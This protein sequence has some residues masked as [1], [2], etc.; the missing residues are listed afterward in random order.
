MART[1]SPLQNEVFSAIKN[2]NSNISVLATAGSGKTTT[3][4]EGL[5]YV[6]RLHKTMFLSFSKSI[7][8]ELKSKIPIHVQ[9]ATLHS[10]GFGMMRRYFAGRG[11]KITDGD[12]MSKYMLKA[13]NYLRQANG[14]DQLTKKQWRIAAL[15]NEICAYARM[16]LT[17]F[18]KENL[19]IM[20]VYYNIEADQQIID[21]A[22]NLLSNSLQ[23]NK[24]GSIEIDFVDMIYFPAMMPEMIDVKYDTVFLD[25]AQDTNAAQFAILERI[26]KPTGRLIAVGDDYQCIYGFSGADINAFKRIRERPNTVTLPLSISY[27]CAKAVVKKAQEIN[28]TIEYYEEAAEG[29]ER[30]GSWEEITELDMILSRTTK[31]LIGLYFQ[32]IEKGVR[33]RVVGKEFEKGL[34]KIA[35][36]CM[37][38]THAGTLYKFDQF[39]QDHITKLREKGIQMPTEHFSYRNLDE[40]VQILTLILNKAQTPKEMLPII[41]DM[42]DERKTA[43]K[44]MTIHRSKGLENDRVFVV[45]K[46]SG[47][48]I[49]PSK[50]AKQQWENIQELNLQFVAYTRA[51]QE[52]VHIN[53]ED[54]G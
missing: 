16:T 2:T 32:L 45:Q 4:L 39:L 46:V 49:M 41:H 10:L 48:P 17:P 31:P 29:I 25:E 6:P 3:I 18:T 12:T 53:L 26:I 21:I 5:K 14:G 1:F 52:L 44:L 34:V 42:F 47:N 24:K 27:R 50:W 33:A 23:V 8:D 54:V 13:A 40:K 36:E 30:E 51:K 7:V 28:P 11:F 19:A 15:V 20:S 22:L 35:E 38:D 37:S 9:A 43:A